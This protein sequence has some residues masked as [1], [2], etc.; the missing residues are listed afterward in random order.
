MCIER[1]PVKHKKKQPT[2]KSNKKQLRVKSNKK[3]WHSRT[4]KKD[5]RTKSPLR[6]WSLRRLEKRQG[7]DLSARL[8]VQHL[9]VCGKGWEGDGTQQA[10]VNVLVVNDAVA[11][12]KH[13]HII[14]FTY[15]LNITSAFNRTK[16]F[17]YHIWKII[18]YSASFWQRKWCS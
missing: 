6:C 17:D 10:G 11:E 13:Y 18:Q 12:W 14:Y 1:H 15:F 2:L 5:N 7:A 3:T 8:G 16:W 4:T 9:V